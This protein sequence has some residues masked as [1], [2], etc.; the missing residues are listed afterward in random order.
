MV[1]KIKNIKSNN[2]RNIN[3]KNPKIK[4]VKMEIICQC[5]IYFLIL[6]KIIY[7]SIIVDNGLYLHFIQIKEC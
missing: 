5:Q 3:D 7:F 1:K 6:F 4:K 2:I